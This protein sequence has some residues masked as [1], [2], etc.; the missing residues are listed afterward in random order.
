MLDG[1][2]GK[3]NSLTSDLA[4]KTKLNEELNVDLNLVKE[5][6]TNAEYQLQLVSDKAFR[7]VETL[8]I[9]GVYYFIHPAPWM[10]KVSTCRKALY[11][12]EKSTNSEYQLQLVSDTSSNLFCVS[13]P[14]LF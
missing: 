2:R 11:F 9:Q 1:Q 7:R 13:S 10:N 5:K 3:V 8:F 12:K 4:I 14:F 6:S